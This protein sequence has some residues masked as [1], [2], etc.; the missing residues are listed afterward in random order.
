MSRCDTLKR[1]LDQDPED[2]FLHFGLAMELVKEK[3]A[4]EA[5]ARFDRVL[6]LD[7]AYIPAYHQ[8][9]LVLIELERRP[10]ARAALQEGV[11]TARAAGNAH[12]VSQ[13]ETI[14]STL[15]G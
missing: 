5:L 7:A 6:V 9:A 14:L 8:K 11:E 10:E 15:P 1:L 3:H 12:A 4:E 2:V 13:M